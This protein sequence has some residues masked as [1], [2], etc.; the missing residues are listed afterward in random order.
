MKRLITRITILVFICILLV[1]IWGRLARF[2]LAL[3]L[4]SFMEARTPAQTREQLVDRVNS[5]SEVQKSV[6]LPVLAAAA[7]SKDYQVAYSAISK[8]CEMKTDAAVGTLRNIANNESIVAKVRADALTHI[9]YTGK[10]SLQD[11]VRAVDWLSSDNGD[12]RLAASTLLWCAGG[13]VACPD[14]LRQNVLKGLYAAFQREKDRELKPHLLSALCQWETSANRLKLLEKAVNSSDTKIRFEAAMEL[15]V[16][17]QYAPEAKRLLRKL[18][19]D[20]VKRIRETALD[21]LKDA[22][23]IEMSRRMTGQ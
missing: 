18:S 16:F 3:H 2:P 1:A 7:H 13:E 17:A 9:G 8:L 19:Q 10:A 6:P 22:E 23:S 5:K 15:S 20:P 11:V 12:L 4:W 21:G 14:S